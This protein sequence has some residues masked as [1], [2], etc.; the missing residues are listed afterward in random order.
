MREFA[1]LRLQQGLCQCLAC[2]RQWRHDV[3]FY[4][5][6]INS[7]KFSNSLVHTYR[8]FP[9]SKPIRS[10]YRFI[11][12]KSLFLHRILSP[13]NST[14]T[15]IEKPRS[16]SAFCWFSSKKRKKALKQRPWKPW[17]W[18]IFI[19]DFERFI[20][21]ECKAFLAKQYHIFLRNNPKKQQIWQQ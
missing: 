18:M 14:H 9:T 17:F 3:I 19:S 5:L 15:T 6:L 21:D 16:M 12:Q 2:C 1:G 13:W 10:K 8:W 7:P 4:T 11:S 20:C